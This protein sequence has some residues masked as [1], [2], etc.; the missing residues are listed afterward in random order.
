MMFLDLFVDFFFLGPDFQHNGLLVVL[1]AG[2]QSDE[3]SN[4][5]WWQDKL[6]KNIYIFFKIFETN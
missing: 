6:G 1:T 2:F 3:I 4:S 5:S